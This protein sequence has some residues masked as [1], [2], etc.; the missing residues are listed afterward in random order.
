MIAEFALRSAL[1]HGEV[2][3]DKL[4]KLGA[5]SWTGIGVAAGFC[6]SVGMV[7]SSHMKMAALLS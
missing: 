6:A 7:E 1:G 3:Q 2:R 5:E 4:L